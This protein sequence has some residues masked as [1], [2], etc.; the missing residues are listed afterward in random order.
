MSVEIMNITPNGD[1]TG[2]MAANNYAVI[3]GVTTFTTWWPSVPPP[4]DV[5]QHARVRLAELERKI[6]SNERSARC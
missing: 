4:P 3:G 5:L 6:S 2:P 1:L